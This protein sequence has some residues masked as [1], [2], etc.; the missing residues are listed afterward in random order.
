MADGVAEDEAGGAP[1]KYIG[2]FGAEHWGYLRFLEGSYRLYAEA[3]DTAVDFLGTSQFNVAYEHGIYTDGYRY[4]GRAIGD[5][6]DN[7]GLGFSLGALLVR[8]DARQ[9]SA[10]LQ[11]VE[12]NRDDRQKADSIHSVSQTAADLWNI[13]VGHRR[14]LGPGTLSA[15]LGFERLEQQDSGAAGADVTFYAQYFLGL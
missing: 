12:L 11:Y 10:R 3:A 2:R 8:D 15:G 14:I 4:R 1:S 6:M 13:E 5:S 9:W 7:D